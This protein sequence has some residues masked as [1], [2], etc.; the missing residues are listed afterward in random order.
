MRVQHAPAQPLRSRE[1]RESTHAAH[2]KADRNRP[3]AFTGRT[4]RLRVLSGQGCGVPSLYPSLTLKMLVLS[5]LLQLLVSSARASR[6]AILG[7]LGANRPHILCKMIIF[8]SAKK[9]NCFHGDAQHLLH[10]GS[11]P[12]HRKR[13]CRVSVPRRTMSFVTGP[14][15]CLSPNH[16]HML[17]PLG[18]LW[19]L[20]LPDAVIPLASSWRIS[21]SGAFAWCK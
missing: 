11:A 8:R 18:A 3:L 9:L 20:A 2:E 16:P 17:S 13:K 15:S 6:R 7:G 12:A 1:L 5:L 21:S 4:V 10:L 14:Q 19:T